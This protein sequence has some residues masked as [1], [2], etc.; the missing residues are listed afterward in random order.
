MITRRKIFRVARLLA[1]SAYFHALAAAYCQTNGHTVYGG[2]AMYVAITQGL[3]GVVGTF[4]ALA[5][6]WSNE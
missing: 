4:I 2:W 5:G 6:D 1:G 3:A